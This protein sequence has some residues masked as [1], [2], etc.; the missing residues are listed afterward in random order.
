MVTVTLYQSGLSS[1]KQ[2][3]VV[4]TCHMYR[5]IRQGCPISAI[6]F[7]FVAEILGIQIRNNKNIEGFTFGN[8]NEHE[9]KVVQHADDCT[10]PLKNDNS[11][12]HALREIESF[13]R[14]YGMKL[15]I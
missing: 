10:L 13:S 2:R 3:M 14:V 15:N 11:M 8:D 4:K 7:L 5:G 1:K 6:I 12:N 9:I